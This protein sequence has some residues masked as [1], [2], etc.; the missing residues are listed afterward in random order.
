M[1]CGVCRITLDGPVPY[2]AHMKGKVHGKKIVCQNMQSEYRVCEVKFTSIKLRDAHLAGEPHRKKMKQT[3]HAAISATPAN[4]VAR[5]RD[6][7]Y[8]RNCNICSKTFNG[9]ESYN[10]HV[11]SNK[12][13]RK[14]WLSAIS[15]CKVCSVQHTCDASRREHLAGEPH[16][17]N[18]ERS[19]QAAN[20]AI[21][22]QP[23][24]R[25]AERQSRHAA[26][27]DSAAVVSYNN[28][29]V[30]P[31][32]FWCSVCK[33]PLTRADER[34]SHNEGKRHMNA[35]RSHWASQERSCSLPGCLAAAGPRVGGFCSQA[36]SDSG[37]DLHLGPVEENYVEK[38]F[39]AK[40]WKLKWLRTSHPMYGKVRKDL[41][42][43]WRMT[44][45][46]PT[47]ERIFQVEMPP[48]FNTHKAYRRRISAKRGRDNLNVVSHYHGT[49]S[50]CNVGVN[51]SSRPC[52]DPGCN[53]CNIMANGFKCEFAETSL[54]GGQRFALRFGVGLYSSSTSGKANDYS[55]GAELP[56]AGKRFR[57]MFV[58]DV[59]AGM[60]YK[61][62][63]ARLRSPDVESILRN[64]YDSVMG[65]PGDNLNFDE[66]VVYDNDAMIPTFYISY[67][68]K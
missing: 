68:L 44:G 35:E 17:K 12:H 57:G 59:V 42:D 2:K 53:V 27:N 60:S 5:P 28:A 49:S 48:Q 29:A 55:K 11:G 26:R 51:A 32:N 38:V 30:S 15:E 25:N 37:V 8:T 4:N 62:D 54:V 40:G 10:D 61:T 45:P 34:E 66:L 16:R 50:L 7:S 64:D 36:H 39:S 22:A 6:T 21:L 67:S 65:I 56:H 23:A 3:S 19:K 18:V 63:A 33:V 46:K 58:V 47:L 41:I 1:F 43:N 31:H 52:L 14:I 13:K 9:P 24:G 20:S